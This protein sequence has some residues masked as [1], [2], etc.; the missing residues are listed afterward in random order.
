MQQPTNEITEEI[1]H[2]RA[3]GCF[4]AALPTNRTVEL[5]DLATDVG[6][7]AD[8]AQQETGKRDELLGDLIARPDKTKASLPRKP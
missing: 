5:Y 7:C 1:A 3:H 2:G 6:E 8:L 4:R